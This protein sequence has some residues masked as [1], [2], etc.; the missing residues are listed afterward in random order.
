MPK[1]VLLAWSGPTSIETDD[2]YNRWYEDVHVPQ[3]IEAVG[4]PATV[5]RQVLVDPRSGEVDSVPK[6]LATYEFDDVDVSTAHAALM[7]AFRAQKLDMSPAIDASAGDMQWYTRLG[8]SIQ[9][10]PQRPGD[11][12]DSNEGTLV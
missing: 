10:S 6:Y 12:H 4:K 7:S 1:A 8:W 9:R 5:T 11:H 2:E 3:V